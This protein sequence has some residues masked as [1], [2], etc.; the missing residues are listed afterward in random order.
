MVQIHVGFVTDPTQSFPVSLE[1]SMLPVRHT[2]DVTICGFS[3][4]WQNSK[5]STARDGKGREV[6]KYLQPPGEDDDWNF[7][8]R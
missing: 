3:D 4:M 5:S 6:E 2:R 7:Y 8:N 1:M